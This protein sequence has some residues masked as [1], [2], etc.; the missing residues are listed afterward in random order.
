ML[1]LKPLEGDFCFVTHCNADERQR[2]RATI[3]RVRDSP[4]NCQFLIDPKIFCDHFLRL[5]VSECSRPQMYQAYPH[6]RNKPLN[7]LGLR[8]FLIP[9]FFLAQKAEWINPVRRWAS[10]AE[11]YHYRANFFS[12]ILPFCNVPKTGWQFNAHTVGEIKVPHTALHYPRKHWTI[13]GSAWLRFYNLLN[14]INTWNTH[15]PS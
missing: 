4:S 15:W 1:A 9:A 13:K 6:F 5:S 10:D 8:A 2:R 3:L 14:A 7:R 12:K 11:S